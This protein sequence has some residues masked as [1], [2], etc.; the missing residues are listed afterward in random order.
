MNRFDDNDVRNRAFL[1]WERAD[2]PCGKVDDFWYEA[3]RQLEAERRAELAQPDR[4]QPV[5][6]H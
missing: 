4:S 2:K 1:L 5:Q 6:R 3:E